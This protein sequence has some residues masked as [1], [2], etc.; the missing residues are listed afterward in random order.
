MRTLLLLAFTLTLS[1]THAD[2]RSPIGERQGYQLART[3]AGVVQG[4]L[5]RPEARRLYARQVHIQR[6]KRSYRA[7]GALTAWER[8]DLQ[9]RLDRSSRA[10]AWQR[11]DGQRRW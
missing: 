4:D 3:H 5:T 9:R 11:N 1:I 10:I 6:I 8:R 2:A 7:D